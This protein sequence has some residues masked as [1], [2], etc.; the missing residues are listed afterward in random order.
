[1]KMGKGGFVRDDFAKPLRTTRTDILVQCPIS[2][3]P[4]TQQKKSSVVRAG[5]SQEC[6]LLSDIHRQAVGIPILDDH[7]T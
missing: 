3:D 2:N 5:V 1:M 4:V 6:L 7:L